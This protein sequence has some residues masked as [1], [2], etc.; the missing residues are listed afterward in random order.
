VVGGL[1]AV[2]A[3]MNRAV[4]W[5]HEETL[6][7]VL[8]LRG[9]QRVIA[10][11]SEPVRLSIGIVIEG[12]G[13]PECEPSCHPYELPP[14]DYV[15]LSLRAKFEALLARWDT[16]RDGYEWSEVLHAARRVLAGEFD[17]RTDMPF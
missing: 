4:V 15:D 13:L 14:D 2:V 17:P 6:A 10:V 1:R 9:D 3:A 16:D 7:G 12:A 8:R 11:V 5:L